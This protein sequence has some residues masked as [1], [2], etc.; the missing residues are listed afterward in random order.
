MLKVFETLEQPQQ[1]ELI[2]TL[3]FELRQKSRL[4]AMLNDKTEIGLMLSRGHVLRGGDCLKA[5][6]GRVIQVQAANED[7]STVHHKDSRMLARASYH[8]GNRHVALQIG[9]GWIRYQHDHVL[10]EM[11]RGLGLKVKFESAPFEPEGGAYGGHSHSHGHSH[12]HSQDD[13]SH[14]HDHHHTHDHAH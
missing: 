5:E 1:T 6:D 2:L 12:D 10:D 3:P 7:V 14:T 11:V 13:E 9:D 4:R 8:L